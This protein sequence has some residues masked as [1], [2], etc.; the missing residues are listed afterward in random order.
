MYGK[1]KD[2]IL[3]YSYTMRNQKKKEKFYKDIKEYEAMEDYKFLFIYCNTLSQYH[4]HKII[5]GFFF[6]FWCI[7]IPIFYHFFNNITTNAFYLGFSIKNFKVIQVA[8]MISIAFFNLDYIN[9]IFCCLFSTKKFF[10]I[11]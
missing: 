8:I 9:Y 4:K 3:R 7:L 2:Q 6:V 5:H 10:F 11:S 1:F